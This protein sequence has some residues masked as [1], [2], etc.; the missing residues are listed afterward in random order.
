M[1][2]KDNKTKKFIEK[3]RIFAD[4]FNYRKILTSFLPN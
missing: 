2:D 3:N 1:G 4:V